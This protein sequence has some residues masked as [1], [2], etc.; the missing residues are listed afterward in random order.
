M[1]CEERMREHELINRAL[2]GDKDAE[3]K[4]I[5]C[6]LP[7]VHALAGRLWQSHVSRDELVHAGSVGLFRAL[8]HYDIDREAKFSTYAMPWILGEMRRMMR[9][10]ECRN[11]SL[12]EMQDTESKSMYDVIQGTPGVSVDRIDLRL[13]LEKLAKEDRLLIC[14]RYFRDKTQKETAILLRKSQAQISRMERRALDQLYELL[15]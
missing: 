14:L 5:C 4:L 2:C 8:H 9:C 7:F 13:A 6:Y 15:R 3:E 10:A 1:L 11:I 12:D